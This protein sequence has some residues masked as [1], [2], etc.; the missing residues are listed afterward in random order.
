MLAAGNG[1]SAWLH[2]KPLRLETLLCT[3]QANVVLLLYRP[4]PGWEQL[5]AYM[6]GLADLDSIGIKKERYAC[7][8]KAACTPLEPSMPIC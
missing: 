6:A 2:N 5:R 8:G 4:R 1:K 3:Q 7:G